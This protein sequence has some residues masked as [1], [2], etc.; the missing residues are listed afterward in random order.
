MHSN[1]AI[2]WSHLYRLRDR[3]S[4]RFCGKAAG[5]RYKGFLELLAPELPMFRE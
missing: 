1:H 5:V 4:A 3:L 2:A